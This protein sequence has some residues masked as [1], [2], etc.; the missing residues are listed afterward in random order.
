MTEEELKNIKTLVKYH[1]KG[2]TVGGNTGWIE[3]RKLLSHIKHLEKV[4][5]NY[6]EYHKSNQMQI[7]KELEEHVALV[8]YKI[9]FGD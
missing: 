4:L 1:T 2:Q 8:N 5:N 6:R 7:K 9:D 3:C